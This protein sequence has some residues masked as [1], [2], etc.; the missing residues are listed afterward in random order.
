MSVYRKS[1]FLGQYIP[2][3][4]FCPKS[5]KVSLILCLIFCAFKFCS[6]T[7]IDNELDNIG[8]IF[9]SFCYP[10]DIFNKTI[11][12]TISSLDK[13]KLYGPEKYPVYLHLPSLD[14]VASFPEDKVKDIVGNTYGAVKLRV[15]H[16]TKKPHN[17]IF[18]D[19]TPVQ[20]K[21]QCYLSFQMLLQ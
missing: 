9:I 6:E 13:P 11:R 14:S 15:A 5:E 7:T 19:V 16:F 20:E 12:K 10:F 21:T 1:T 3:R 17:G 4:S 8:K 18:K 2:R